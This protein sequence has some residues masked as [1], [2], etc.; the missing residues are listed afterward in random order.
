[1]PAVENSSPTAD[2]GPFDPLDPSAAETFTTAFARPMPIERA[3]ALEVLAKAGWAAAL[4][5][6]PHDA[7]LAFEFSRFF[8][9]IG[10]I[11]KYKSYG[12]K[13][14]APFGYSIFALDD[15]KGF[16]V[17]LHRTAK[18]EAFHILCVKPEA[19]ALLA[20]PAE[21]ETYGE[22]FVELW[23]RS[24]GDPTTSELAF[25][26]EPGDV[27]VIDH[28][29][30][31]H[32]I[33]GCVLEEFATT[34]N[35][36]VT[37]LFDQNAAAPAAIPA[38]HRELTEVLVDCASKPP[39][40][41][42]SRTEGAWETAKLEGPERRLV[43][44]PDAGLVGYHLTVPADAPEALYVADGTITTISCLAGSVDVRLRGGELRLATG[45]TAPLA[46]GEAAVIR[47][48]AEPSRMSVCEV[49]SALA[50]GDFRTA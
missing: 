5:G 15:G 33:V 49:A 36:A 47:A 44:L 10:F 13:F 17:Q 45:D 31:V 3:E 43:D 29:E 50:F 28:L 39:S 46:P 9:G 27:L 2:L 1:M 30:V 48:G 35:D 42:V 16:S 19:F 6:A 18:V 20:S 7:R 26:P 23:Q 25:R 41:F 12:T 14:A 11:R 37:R 40:R 24:Q 21:W 34:S 8:A 38:Q 32:S 4:A 22:E